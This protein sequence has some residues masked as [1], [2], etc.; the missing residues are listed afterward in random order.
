M[1][2]YLPAPAVLNPHLQRLILWLVEEQPLPLPLLRTTDPEWWLELRRHHLLPL[3][4]YRLQQAGRLA[5]LPP[6]AAQ[7]LRN[8][9]AAALKLFLS[10]EAETR[11]LLAA[12]A[13]AGFEVIFLKGADL[14]LRVYEDPVTRPMTDLDL[15]APPESVGALRHLLDRQGYFLATD[16]VNP[17][18]G[19]R[20]RYRVGL[21]FQSPPPASLLVDLHWGLAGVAGYYRLLYGPLSD[22]AETRDWQGISVRVLSPEHTLLHLCL[23]NYDEG[24]TALKL[25]D[26]VLALH[27]LPLNWQVF[28]AEAV[29]CRCQAPVFLVLRGLGNL[30]PGAVPFP[31]LEELASYVPSG[32]ERL[33]LRHSHHPLARLLGPLSHKRRL[34]DWVACLAAV[35]W[36][37]AAYLQAV[38]GS[39][40]R[41]AYLAASLQYLVSGRG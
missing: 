12:L 9:Y 13:A 17:R 30:L 1:I 18:P 33:V 38:N 28:T 21:H 40:G 39:P 14:R 19:F 27:R 37:D 15:L 20:E 36:P 41:L 5:A 26:L 7:L 3:L 24:D 8:D 35:L 34:S 22:R 11:R 29:R 10:Q 16:S 31:V 2:P 23:H 32:T 4:Y 25:L 6:A